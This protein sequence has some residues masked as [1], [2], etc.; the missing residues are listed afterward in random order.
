MVQENSLKKSKIIVISG[1]TAVG[2]S[3]LAV[4]LA[5]KINA[6]I[7]SADSMQIYK[8]MDIGTG[9]INNLEKKDITHH[10]LDIVSPDSDYSVSDYVNDATKC[11]NDI[12]SRNKNIILVGGTGLYINALLNGHNFAASPKNDEIRQ[13][14]NDLLESKGVDYLYELLKNIDENSTNKISKNDTKRVIRA[15]EIFETTGKTKTESVSILNESRYD[16]LFLILDCERKKLYDRINLRVDKMVQLGLFNEVE[17][18]IK[19]KYCNSMKAIGYKEIIQFL[20]GEID[21]QVTIENIKQNSRHYAKRQ[22]TYFR[23][24]KLEKEFIQY[25]DVSLVEKKV[26]DFLFNNKN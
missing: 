19:Y 9:K 2:K 5:Q 10:M 3:D 17:K 21:K 14:Y 1:P 16:Y 26:I 24:V 7:I 22:M 4:G 23:W 8:G 25:D 20:D 12:C 18:L 13:K 15:L 6:E 11:I